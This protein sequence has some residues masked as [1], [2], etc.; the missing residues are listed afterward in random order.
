MNLYK[1]LERLGKVL[2]FCD[3]AL[4]SR[5]LLSESQTSS[6]YGEVFFAEKQKHRT[7]QVSNQL[8]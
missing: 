8:L 1:K 3:S 4:L 5:M 7:F 6:A 2:A